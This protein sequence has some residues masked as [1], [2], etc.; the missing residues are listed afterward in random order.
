M[1]RRPYIKRLITFDVVSM[2]DEK[3]RQTDRQSLC[4]GRIGIHVQRNGYL[5]QVCAMR[6]RVLFDISSAEK[7]IP[8]GFPLFQTVCRSFS[9]S[10]GH[11][12]NMLHTN[13]LFAD[14][15]SL[16]LFAWACDKN[17]WSVESGG[18]AFPCLVLYTCGQQRQFQA[19][20]C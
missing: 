3:L 5:F 12:N 15:Y 7:W 11:C 6:K 18:S 19:H 2:S 13:M 8:L 17:I 16:H 9:R 1:V 10:R 4:Q 20:C 14:A